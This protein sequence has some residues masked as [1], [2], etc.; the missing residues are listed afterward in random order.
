MSG[1]GAAARPK[2]RRRAP[3]ASRAVMHACCGA[4]VRPKFGARRSIVTRDPVRGP[5]GG[6]PCRLMGV[7]SAAPG[8]A[9]CAAP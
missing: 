1:A 7:S 6:G 5:K 9:G 2:A 4:C 3:R 8:A